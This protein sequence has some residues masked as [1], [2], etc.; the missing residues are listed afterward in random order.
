MHFGKIDRSDFLIPPFALFYPYVL[1]ANAFDLPLA[2]HRVWVRSAV[3]P[4]L[5]VALCFLGLILLLL[6][7]VAFGR[8]FRVGIDAENPDRLITTGVFHLSRNPTYV[9]FGCEL[10]GQFLVHPDMLLLVYLLAGLALL[11]RQ[12]LREEAF[13]RGHYGAP[14]AHYCREVR[15]YL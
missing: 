15:R 2:D 12:V 4:W 7:L 6:T 13:M 10:L 5:G 3:L 14:F 9:A 8:S 11:H 1:F